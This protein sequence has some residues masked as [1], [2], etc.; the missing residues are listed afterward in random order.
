M[1]SKSFFLIAVILSGIT[2]SCQHKKIREPATRHF[3]IEK[4]AE[5]VYAAIHNDSGGYAVCNAG[6]IDLGNKTVVLDPFISP[7]AARD[8]KRQAEYLTGRPVS[9]VL[10]LDLHYDHTYGNQAFKKWYC[11][12]SCQGSSGA[13]ACR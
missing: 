10:N 5:S 7:M 4:L 13:W 6:I 1:N 11:V 12:E 3:K 8:L 2:V 9:L